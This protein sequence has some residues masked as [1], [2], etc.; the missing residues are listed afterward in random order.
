MVVMRSVN[1]LL[2]LLL[3]IC[4][5]YLYAQ[6]L[7]SYASVARTSPLAAA[8]TQTSTATGGRGRLKMQRSYV[9]IIDGVIF[10][11]QGGRPKGISVVWKSLIPEL[12]RQFPAPSKLY[13]LD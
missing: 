12:A 5:C 8:T 11:L 13:F 1:K 6:Y 4:C 10:R 2:P 7:Y 9:V 3:I